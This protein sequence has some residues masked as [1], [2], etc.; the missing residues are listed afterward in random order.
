MTKRVPAYFPGAQAGREGDVHNRTRFQQLLL[1]Q[2]CQARTADQRFL[3][4]LR[5]LMAFVVLP[6]MDYGTSFADARTTETAQDLLVSNFLRGANL[7]SR[8]RLVRVTKFVIRNPMAIECFAS[9]AVSAFEVIHLDEKVLEFISD[10][11]VVLLLK[12]APSFL[13]DPASRKGKLPCRIFYSA[14]YR[15]V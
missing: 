5:S 14:L 2:P 3:D 12:A 9:S 8:T 1:Q 13:S 10:S 15:F 4:M 6:E 11:D 7:A